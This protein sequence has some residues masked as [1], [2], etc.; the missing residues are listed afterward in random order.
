[1]FR[2][3][4]EDSYLVAF[5]VMRMVSR[6]MLSKSMVSGLQRAY[7]LDKSIR[8]DFENPEEGRFE[9]SLEG[10]C[11]RWKND[12]GG[13]WCHKVICGKLGARIA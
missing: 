8:K 5:N 12:N 6:P 11:M 4:D 10:F 3:E 7:K 1:M 13:Y 2:E 9:K